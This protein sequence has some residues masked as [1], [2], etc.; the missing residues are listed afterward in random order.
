MRGAFNRIREP[1]AQIFYPEHMKGS[2][3]GFVSTNA[4]WMSV[5]LRR[6]QIPRENSA[7]RNDSREF[8]RSCSSVLPASGHNFSRGAYTTRDRSQKPHRQECL[9]YLPRPL[10]GADNENCAQKG[11]GLPWQ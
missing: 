11:G 1:V 3:W 9:C 8:F 10:P 2:L 7:L 6:K 5:D 4:H